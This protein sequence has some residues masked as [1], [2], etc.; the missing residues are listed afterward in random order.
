MNRGNLHCVGGSFADLASFWERYW[1]TPVID[2]T[3]VN[4]RFDMELKWDDSGWPRSR[5]PEALKQALLNQLGL[6]LV[7]SR[8]P[9]ER[10][11][12]EKAN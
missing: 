1:G 5:N 6:E 10:L 4:E 2:Q 9:G 11:V 8:E 12:V 3:K 7:P